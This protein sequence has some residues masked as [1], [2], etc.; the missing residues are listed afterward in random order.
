ML[1]T[2]ST[3]KLGVLDLENDQRDWI[4]QFPME[5]ATE[6]PAEAEFQVD[7]LRRKSE[8]LFTIVRYG[9][10]MPIVLPEREAGA[11]TRPSSGHHHRR[12]LVRRAKRALSPALTALF[13]AYVAIVLITAW[14]GVRRG[15]SAD[16]GDSA[17]QTSAPAADTFGPANRP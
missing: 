17:S 4:G 14:I 7:S 6:S 10:P 13:V 11:E 3:K 5:M 12:S 2:E 15:N 1:S 16:K 9:R 8:T